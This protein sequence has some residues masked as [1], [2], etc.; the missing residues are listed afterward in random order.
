MST[1]V[2]RAQTLLLLVVAAGAPALARASTASRLPFV[3]VK[4]DQEIFASSHLTKTYAP[5]QTYL[6]RAPR[7][8]RTDL[9]RLDR[10]GWFPADDVPVPDASETGRVAQQT[11]PAREELVPADELRA[12]QPAQAGVHVGIPSAVAATGAALGGLVLLVQVL[13]GLF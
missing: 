7:L 4:S 10:W 3:A 12:D 11:S 2:R 5:D 9:A 13:A 6:L 8:R 1:T